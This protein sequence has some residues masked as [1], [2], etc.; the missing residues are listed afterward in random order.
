MGEAA[1]LCVGDVLLGRA[2]L[3]GQRHRSRGLPLL[4]FISLVNH[5]KV[6]GA[7]ILRRGLGKICAGGANILRS[8]FDHVERVSVRGLPTPLGDPVVPFKQPEALKFGDVPFDRPSGHLAKIGKP[9]NAR[10]AF[11]SLAVVMIGDPVEDDL[12]CGFEASLS[13]GKRGHVVAHGATLRGKSR[14]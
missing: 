12:R 11:A 7:H 10:E 14:L 5:S 3:I 6:K 1:L 2:P 8:G 9:V 4:L 13:H